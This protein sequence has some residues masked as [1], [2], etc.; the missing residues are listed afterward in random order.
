MGE[1][2]FHNIRIPDPLYLSRPAQW[3]AKTDASARMTLVA[4]R[5]A[6]AERLAALL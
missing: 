3:M 6:I 2:M 1:K 5:L 4:K